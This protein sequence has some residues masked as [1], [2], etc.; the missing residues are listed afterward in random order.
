MQRQR[1]PHTTATPTFFIYMFAFLLPSL[2][3]SRVNALQ[4]FNISSELAGDESSQPQDL[5]MHKQLGKRRDGR[6]PGCICNAEATFG[7]IQ[8]MSI[9]LAASHDSILFLGH[10]NVM[11]AYGD[12]YLTSSRHLASKLAVQS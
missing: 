10:N 3:F 1:N 12:A 5:A 2:F 6:S 4:V 7:D 8:A 11:E 9:V